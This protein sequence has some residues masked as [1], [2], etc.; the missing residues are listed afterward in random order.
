MMKNVLMR[1]ACNAQIHF[2]VEALRVH[3]PGF[4]TVTYCLFLS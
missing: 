3:T 2:I 4:Y 1:W